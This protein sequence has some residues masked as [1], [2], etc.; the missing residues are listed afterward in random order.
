MGSRRRVFTGRGANEAQSPEPARAATL[1]NRRSGRRGAPQHVAAATPPA[2]VVTLPKQITVT[3]RY[4]TH[5]KRTT[6]HKAWLQRQDPN[7]KSAHIYGRL[8]VNK[9]RELY[10]AKFD[11]QGGVSFKC[12][13]VNKCKECLCITKKAYRLTLKEKPTLGGQQFYQR[14]DGAWRVKEL[15]L[16]TKSSGRRP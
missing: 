1:R 4:I 2:I 3:L 15:C 10:F 6:E 14:R 9:D 7:D 16:D 5:P 11:G 8:F 13:L 12:W